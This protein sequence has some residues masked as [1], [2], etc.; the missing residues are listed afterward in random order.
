MFAYDYPVLG[1]FLSTLYFFLMV[2]WLVI[3]F[4]VVAD[5][6]R[7]GDLGG[8]AKTMW[9][10]LVIV[11]PYLGVFAYVIARGGGME[12]RD[13]ARLE[14]RDEAFREYVRSATDGGVASELGRFADMRD[15]GLITDEEFQQQ[16]AK[17]LA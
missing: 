14:A 4:R 17:L 13:I 9:L 16:K 10:L 6:F 11:L 3:L 2:I 8:V 7:S 15:R 12:R 1:V 5:I